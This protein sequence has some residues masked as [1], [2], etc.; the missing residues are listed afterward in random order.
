[1][2]ID[3]HLKSSH[4]LAAGFL[5]GSI[6]IYS[7]MDNKIGN[8]SNKCVMISKNGN[9]RDPVWQVQWDNTDIYG[10]LSLFSVSSDGR[11]VRWTIKKVCM[12]DW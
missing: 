9:H 4:F 7:L 8:K 10:E 6:A 5:D 1:M 12:E 3:V 11:I 2:S